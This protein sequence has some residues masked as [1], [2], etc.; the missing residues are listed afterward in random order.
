MIHPTTLA[1]SDSDTCLF[2][3]GDRLI[4]DITSKNPILPFRRTVDTLNLTI[5][6]SLT[7]G[8]I[9]IIN[10]QMD[11]LKEP[12]AVFQPFAVKLFLSEVDQTL[13]SRILRAY[14][15]LNWEQQSQY[16]GK[17][18]TPL[19]YKPGSAEKKCL[20]CKQSFFPRF[21]PAVMVLIQKDD[22]LLLARSPHFA[23]GVYSAIAGFIDIGETAEEAAHREVREEVG[24]E[25]TQLE[26]FATQTWPF[27]DSFMIAF[28]AQYLRGELKID[29]KEIED[30]R[31][32]SV[33]DLPLTPPTASIAKY[34]IQ[35][36]IKG[37]K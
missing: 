5:Q 26:Y 37:N 4:V 1:P 10:C 28:K 16:C 30:A 7:D 25:I 6:N 17:C 8:S 29:E 33:S 31:W 18:G 2:F 32:F 20:A 27:P 15:R 21:S 22:Q 9:G 36:V 12:H 19:E 24:I 3:T 34:L 35:S 11:P 14:H 23:P 13:Q